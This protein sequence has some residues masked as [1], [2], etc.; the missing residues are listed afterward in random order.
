MNPPDV[1]DRYTEIDFECL[2]F[3]DCY[4]YGI[5]WS[6]EEFAMQFDLD[7]I[8][9]WVEPAAEDQRYQFWVCPAE[10]CFKNIA[11]TQVNLNWKGLAP[12]CQIQD[13]RRHDSRV[14]PN[15]SIQ[16][17]WNIELATPEGSIALWATGFELRIKGPVTLSNTQHVVKI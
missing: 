14:T 17:R 8:V 4:V 7:Y 10:L 6:I 3:H 12:E 1:R 2:G 15:G 5:R 13:I 16:W 9:K 11:D